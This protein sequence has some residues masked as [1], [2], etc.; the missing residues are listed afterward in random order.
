MLF[1]L[2]NNVVLSFF[3]R[4]FYTVF[5]ILYTYFLH[6]SHTFY[7]YFSHFVHFFL[8]FFIKYR[9]FMAKYNALPCVFNALSCVFSLIFYNFLY[10]YTN[11]VRISLHTHTALCFVSFITFCTF[12]Q[13]FSTYCTKLHS[14]STIAC[15]NFLAHLHKLFPACRRT[16]SSL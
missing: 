15:T 5:C 9:T 7:I 14:Q 11:I 10:I 2:H 16:F 1:I 8:L 3:L 13:I 6:I 4:A 12:A